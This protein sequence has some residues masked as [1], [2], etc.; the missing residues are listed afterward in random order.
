MVQFAPKMVQFAPGLVQFSKVRHFWCKL[1]HSW[2]KLHQSWCRVHHFLCEF[3][4]SGLNFWWE[5]FQF[6]PPNFSFGTPNVENWLTFV[7]YVILLTLFTKGKSHKFALC[8]QQDLMWFARSLQDHWSMQHK[9]CDV[10]G[11][12]IARSLACTVSKSS[13]LCYTAFCKIKFVRAFFGV[14][15]FF[16]VRAALVQYLPWL[17]KS[18][19]LPPN[20]IQKLVK[21]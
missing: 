17:L 15:G 13:F 11:K 5:I 21:C 7:C 2:C 3:F 18:Q 12:I 14:L 19:C 10:I 20:Q 6:W 1:R 9:N 8:L 4:A 16:C